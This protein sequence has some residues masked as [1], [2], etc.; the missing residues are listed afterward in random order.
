L[1]TLVLTPYLACLGHH[2]FAALVLLMIFVMP[3]SWANTPD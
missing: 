1:A 2:L 3:V